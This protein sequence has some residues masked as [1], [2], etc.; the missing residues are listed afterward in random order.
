MAKKSL[1]TRPK[2]DI[3]TS[4]LHDFSKEIVRTVKGA[5][6]IHVTDLEGTDAT[7]K[8]LENCLSKEKPKLVFLIKRA[9]N[10]PHFS[11]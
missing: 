7:R 9:R 4:Y 1:T 2:H 11:A 10:L 8:N 3:I 5:P 6:D